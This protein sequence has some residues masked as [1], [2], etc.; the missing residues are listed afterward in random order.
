V[1]RLPWNKPDPHEVLAGLNLRMV[2]H[3]LA[4]CVGQGF[5]HAV[6]GSSASSRYTPNVG[7]SAGTL[8]PAVPDARL[9]SDFIDR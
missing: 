4:S 2:S 5:S 6:T 1:N 3:L 7:T 8:S 9:P